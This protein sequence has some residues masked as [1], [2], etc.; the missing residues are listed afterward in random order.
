[1]RRLAAWMPTNI[2]SAD[3]TLVIASPDYRAAGDGNAAGASTL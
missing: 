3:Y 2:T 1:M